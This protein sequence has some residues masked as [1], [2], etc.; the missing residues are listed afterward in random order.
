MV[1]DK[2]NKEHFKKIIL[3]YKNRCMQST[4]LN[5]NRDINLMPNSRIAIKDGMRMSDL[6]N[7]INF[8]ILNQYFERF[9]NDDSMIALMASV[10]HLCRLT[11][12]KSQSQFPFWVPKNNIVER[13]ILLLLKQR[14]EKYLKIKMLILLS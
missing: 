5:K 11:D 2:T 8:Y 9:E 13:N 12:L 14:V 1:V 6:F 4:K 3:K 7:P 10:L